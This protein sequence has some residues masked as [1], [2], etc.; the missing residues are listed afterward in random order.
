M[1]IGVSGKSGSG[2]SSIS[3]YLEK[4][5]NYKLLDLDFV[6]KEIIKRYKKE[7]LD[8]VNYDILENEEID[9]KKLGKILFNDK[10]LMEKYN[11]FVYEKLNE[12]INKHL[13]DNLILDSI[14]LPIMSIFEKIDVKILVMC[15]D[16]IRVER[17][18]NRDKIDLEYLKSREKNGL[19]YKEDDFDYLIDNNKDYKEQVE[20]IIKKIAHE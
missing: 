14:F 3:K 6:S 13:N 9:S 10:G 16:N 11:L 18:L 7:I 15:D 1:I 2:K 5:L 20:Q 8:I 12:E 4:R 19:E 17:I